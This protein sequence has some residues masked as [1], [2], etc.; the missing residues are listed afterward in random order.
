MDEESYDVET[1]TPAG[2]QKKLGAGPGYTGA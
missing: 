2:Y 1:K